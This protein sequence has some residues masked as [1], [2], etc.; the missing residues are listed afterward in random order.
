METTEKNKLRMKLFSKA[1]NILREAH[2]EDFKKIYHALLA[3]NGLT[4]QGKVTSDL[5]DRY[6]GG[7]NNG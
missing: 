2:K 7:L 6:L 3:E 1:E 4:P 5:V